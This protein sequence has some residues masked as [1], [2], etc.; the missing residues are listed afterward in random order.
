MA[1]VEVSHLSKSFDGR[2]AV[3]GI[4]FVVEQ[5]EVFGLLGP[6]GAGKS[7]TISMLCGLL[8]PTS[9][10]AL[11]DG[12]S[13]H[14][15]PM[16][17]KRLLGVVP[18]DIALYPTLSARENLQFWAKM[19]GLGRAKARR[20][21]EEVLAIVGL[22]ERAKDRIETYSGG[23]KR[24]INVAVGLLHE[25]RVL[26][27]DEPTVG[28]DPQ[29]RNHILETVKTLNENGLT[30]IYTSHYMEEVEALCDRIAIMDGGKIIA[31]GTLGQLRELVGGM[32]VISIDVDQ[33]S[34]VALARVRA[35]AEVDRVNHRDTSLEVLS[36]QGR[37]VLAD[38]ISELGGAGV[39]VHSVK[40]REPNLESV[41]LHLTGK[42]LRD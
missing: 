17:V 15:Q 5:G 16:E 42:S 41:F 8:K 23:M 22:A 2:M 12:R 10:D 24:R 39:D 20:R 21:A 29:S 40:I 32:D 38:V 6:N 33:V 19:Y 30:V 26:L 36:L 13:I 1:V 28:I 35:V 18:Q 25:P 11:I 9:G 7:T 14:S 34:E 4:S 31:L 37:R 27:L 3:S